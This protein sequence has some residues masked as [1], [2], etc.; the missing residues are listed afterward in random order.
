VTQRPFALLD[1]DG[2][3]IK[4]RH[5]LSDPDRVELIPRA[6][7]GLRQLTQM[8]V[9]LL[10]ITNQ[11]G[12]G[13]GFFD[14]RQ[15]NR[16]HKRMC[17]LLAKESVILDGIYYCPHTPE[18]EC[19]CRK[20]ATE[21]VRRAS[22]KHGFD[23]SNI[24]V[25]GDKKIDVELGVNVGATTF[26]VRTGYGALVATE[27]LVHPDYVVDDLAHAAA[28]IENLLITSK[29]RGINGIT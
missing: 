13:R 8:G 6:A 7:V 18:D 20:P 12:V 16:I 21:L 28:T 10:V 14:E 17:D 25:I 27:S 24:F 19:R 15:L 4:E 1:R 9:G 22:E 2:T 11:S 23:P 29:G 5:Y 26:L 3:I